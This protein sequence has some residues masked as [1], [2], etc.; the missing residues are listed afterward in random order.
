MAAGRRPMPL[1]SGADGPRLQVG[2]DVQH[3]KWGEGVVVDIKGSGD[4]AQA[5]VRFSS[6]GEKHLLM[7]WAPLV[8]I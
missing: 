2:D 3:A 8:K 1:P 5:S 6:V 4:E 7:S